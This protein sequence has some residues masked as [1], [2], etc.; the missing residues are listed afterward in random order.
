[1]KDRVVEHPNR[2]R[3]VPVAGQDGVYDAVAVPGTITEPGTPINKALLLS[4]ST[5]MLYGLSEANANVNRSIE[6]AYNGENNVMVVI[7]TTDQNGNPLLGMNL[8]VACTNDTAISAQALTTNSTGKLVLVY[9]RNRSFTIT[10]ASMIGMINTTLSVSF[11]TNT[12]DKIVTVNPGTFFNIQQSGTLEITVSGAYAI[13]P[14]VKTVDL[15]CVGGGGGGGYGNELY[16]GGGGGYT[17]TLKNVVVTTSIPTRLLNCIIGAA[18]DRGSNGGTTSITS[19]LSASG[20]ATGNT[21]TGGAGGSGGGGGGGGSGGSNGSNGIKGYSGAGG[22]GQG[23]TTRA[24][25]EATGTL[26][27]GGGGGTQGTGGAG[28]GGQGPDGNGSGATGGTY[29]GGGGGT[30][31]SG[32]QGIILVRW[33]AA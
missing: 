17:A 19:L 7:P 22:V 20:G 21:Y 33:Y 32:Y 23:T 12:A 13:A 16:A 4:D 18:G 15:F 10:R 1:M 31:H 24:F 9:P 5:A 26:Y 14:H 28:G 29:Y 8:T 3:L 11:N 30:N 2:V 25:G 27:S 6:L